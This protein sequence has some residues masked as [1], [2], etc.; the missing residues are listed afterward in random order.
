MERELER[1]LPA[2]DADPA[3]VH[4]AMRYSVLGGG[5]RLRPALVL[6][7]ARLAGAD[8]ASVLGI[9]CAV[10]FV[11]TYSLIHDDLP[12][13]DDDDL[14]R[15]RPSCHKAFGEAIAI[16]AGD[17]L[18]TYAFE[19]L[20]RHAP[21][22]ADTPALVLDLCTAAGTGGMV[23]GQVVDLLSEGATADLA[24]VRSI[25]ER[26]TAALLACSLRLGARAGG[27]DATLVA[28]LGAF[29]ERLGLAFQIVDDVLDE[30]G[31]ADELGK[32]PGKDRQRGKLTFPAAVGIERSRE[33]AAELVREAL[34]DVT[35]L[36]GSDLLAGVCDLVVSRRT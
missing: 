27:G 3:A 18:N 1:L 8:E 30:E 35:D 13:M 22:R 29:G 25:H 17:A 14:R 9:A 36:P 20:V 23:G 2:A 33:M 24:I 4:E 32:T 6:L 7:G 31:L 21:N 26:K 5:K 19:V 16:L 15:G 34:H 10:E 11:H 28:K 12:A